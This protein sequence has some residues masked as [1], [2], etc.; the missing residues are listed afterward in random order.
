MPFGICTKYVGEGRRAVK[1]GLAGANVYPILRD[2]HDAMWVGTWPAGLTQFLDGKTKTYTPKEGLPG[3]VTSLADDGQGHL[4]IGTHGGLAVISHGKIERP[5]GPVESLPVVQAILKIR[6][7]TLLLGTQYGIDR[8]AIKQQNR[9]SIRLEHQQEIHNGDVRVI[10]EGRNGD[11]WFGGYNGLN[12]LH[13]GSLTHWAE[14]DGSP[15][16]TVRAIY[17]DPEGVIWL[18][19]T[20]PVLHVM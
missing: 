3:L 7:G 18:A 20:M 4:W 6:D 10:V 15:S 16:N 19:R 1:D 2:S 13:N 11:I 9:H 14:Q 12:R 5:S 8:Y 17:E